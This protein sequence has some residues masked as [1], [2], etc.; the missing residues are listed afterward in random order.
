MAFSCHG[1]RFMMDVHAYVC[2]F[3]SLKGYKSLLPCLPGE[4]HLVKYFVFVKKMVDNSYIF[5]LWGKVPPSKSLITSTLSW[6]SAIYVI[7]V[8]QCYRRIVA[9]CVGVTCMVYAIWGERSTVPNL[10]QSLGDF[11]IYKNYIFVSIHDDFLRLLSPSWSC[12]LG[13]LCV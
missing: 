6:E 11:Y 7:I 3:T 13:L 12:S 9:L 5:P 4:L 8:I 10:S 1:A 2:H